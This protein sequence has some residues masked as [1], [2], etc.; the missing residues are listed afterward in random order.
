M[1]DEFA[2]LGAISVLVFGTFNSFNCKFVR[3]IISYTCLETVRRHVLV[4]IFFL[5]AF[6]YN[7][8][9]LHFVGLMIIM[10][11]NWLQ[12]FDYTL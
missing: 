2:K 10:I 3:S 11:I 7:I 4:E 9:Q 1:L 5:F 8:C 6:I 12:M